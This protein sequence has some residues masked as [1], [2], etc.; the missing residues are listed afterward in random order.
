M[1]N[2]F[3]KDELEKL[4]GAF[5]NVWNYIGGEILECT[6]Q[7]EVDRDTVIEVVLDANRLESFHSSDEEVKKILKH[8]RA[9]SYEE[10]IEIAKGRFTFAMYS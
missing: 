4:Y 7:N 8:F 2:N 3:K 5:W 1:K 9:F 10:Q 6:G